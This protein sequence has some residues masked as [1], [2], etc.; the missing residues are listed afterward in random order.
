MTISRG[1]ETLEVMVKMNRAAVENALC[2]PEVP[3]S[4]PRYIM[5]GG[6]LFQPLSS[7]LL[8]NLAGR[9]NGVLP[10]HLQE[11]AN[12][13][14]ELRNKGYTELIGLTFVLPT[15]ATQGYDELRFS[16]LLAVNGQQV[17]SFAELAALLD[18]PTENGLIRLDFNKPPYTVY[19]DRAT[20]DAVN[21]QLQSTAIPNLRVVE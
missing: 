3:G 10:L 1:G 21:T 19:L 2:K 15:A 11:L 13:E 8:E 16:Q 7:T 6:M 4:Q 17:N 12:R 14:E 5:W 18:A 9:T 20:V